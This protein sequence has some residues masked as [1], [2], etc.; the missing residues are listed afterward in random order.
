MSTMI[1]RTVYSYTHTI[2]EPVTENGNT[3]IRIIGEVKSDKAE[4][5]ARYMANYRKENSVPRAFV[6][7]TEKHETL[8]G[9]SIEKFMEIAEQLPPRAKKNEQ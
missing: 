8:Y 2:A 7:K 1:T 5:G 6:L 3:T 4:L 9:V